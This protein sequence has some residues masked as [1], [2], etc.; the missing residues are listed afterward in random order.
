MD[1]EKIK[2]ILLCPQCHC[3]D[4][5]FY[6]DELKCN[7]CFTSF[8]VKHNQLDLRLQQRKKVEVTFNVGQ[9]FIIDYP[10]YPLAYNEMQKVNFE[11]VKVPKH[12]TK[13]LMSYF[14]KSTNE[15]NFALDL[16]CGN[17]PHKNVIEIAGYNW[18]GLDYES[19]EAE[20]LADAYS[21]PFIDNCM[22]FVLSIAILEHIQN[23][24]IYA[25]EVFRV[26]KPGGTFIGSVAFLEGFHS[27]S[28]Y[29]HTQYGTYYT[30]KSAGFKDIIVSPNKNWHVLKAQSS[31]LFLHMPVKI[32]RSITGLLNILHR[33]WWE[34]I[35][36]KIGRK[37]GE[38]MRILMFSASFHF[39]AKKVDRTIYP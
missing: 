29:H 34:V 37:R 17:G 25:S 19:K 7:S 18:V 28:Y 5:V 31:R 22:D 9:D 10:F 2:H 3:R 23:P 16:G 6:E 26:L 33:I 39:I 21:L 11:G 15:N 12:L 30:L 32:A 27:H 8:P 35:K 20:I 24:F 38:N 36:L 14:P 1:L 13:E 4:L